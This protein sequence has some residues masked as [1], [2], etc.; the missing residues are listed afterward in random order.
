MKKHDAN[1]YPQTNTVYHLR[2]GIEE[3]IQEEASD[4]SWPY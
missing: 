4:L 1:I 2:E 3:A